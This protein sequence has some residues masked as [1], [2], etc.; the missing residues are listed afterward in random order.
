VHFQYCLTVIECTG[1]SIV[2]DAEFRERAA[3]Q[4]FQKFVRVTP[5]GVDYFIEL[6]YDPILNMNVE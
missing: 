2:P 3:S 5:L 6:R 4:R 1:E